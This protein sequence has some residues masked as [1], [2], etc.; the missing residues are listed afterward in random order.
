MLPLRSIKIEKESQAY[1][2]KELLFSFNENGVYSPLNI[3][4][5]TR[6]T[7]IPI[8]IYVHIQRALWLTAW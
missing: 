2:Y 5:V 7:A 1:I 8:Y 4:I 3:N 6:V